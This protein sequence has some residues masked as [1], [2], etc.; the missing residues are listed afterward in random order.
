LREQAKAQDTYL[1]DATPA[2][3]FTALIRAVLSSG[4]GHIDGRDGSKPDTAAA[5]DKK[6]P[7]LR[8]LGWQYR[9]IKDGGSWEPQGRLIGWIDTESDLFLDP[10]S[11]YAETQ[12]LANAENLT[13]PVSARTLWTH[14]D[15]AGLL[16]GKDAEHMTVVRYV[17]GTRK[18]VLY[19]NAVQILGLGPGNGKDIGDSAEDGDPGEDAAGEGDPAP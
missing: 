6:A 11:A 5:T 15:D 3:R 2:R 13:L 12:L 9:E 19:L 10:D 18:R 7:Y 14:L 1:K 16:Q 17:G 4:R 8:A